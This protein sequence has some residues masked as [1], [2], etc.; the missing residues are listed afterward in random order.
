MSDDLVSGLDQSTEAPAPV[1][2]GDPQPD[3]IERVERPKE[4]RQT[5]RESVD[6]QK[7]DQAR[8]AGEQPTDRARPDDQPPDRRQ[9][10]QRDPQTGKFRP[11]EQPQP[12]ARAPAPGQPGAG[13]R[14]P[15]GWSPQAKNMF[16]GLPPAIKEAIA[17]SEFA[18]STAIDQFK[19]L[20]GVQQYADN[21]T[22]NGTTLARALENYTGI[23]TLLQ[24]DPAA[25]LMQIFRNMPGI[26][27]GIVI[28]EMLRRMGFRPNQPGQPQPQPGS[29]PQPQPYR[30]PRLDQM[31]QQMQR[32]QQMRAVEQRRQDEAMVRAA[33]NMTARFWTDP[34]YPYAENV[35]DQMVEII[36]AAKA[37]GIPPQGI[38]LVEVY[39]AACWRNPQVREI[40]Q[41]E[42]F[43]RRA[44]GGTPSRQQA[45]T[46]RA[47]A[48]SKAV[49]GSPRVGVTPGE[50]ASNP[51]RSTR[52]TI[53]DAIQA[54]KGG[55]RI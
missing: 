31:W 24:R 55:Q 54:Q 13:I 43:R 47:R 9:A 3:R 23:E 4:L 49:T 48:A 27:P 40:L 17:Q 10:A 45:A 28:Q 16:G 29:P 5:I 19:T 36:E 2:R 51:N 44:A 20:N 42:D 1:E 22:R 18:H 41:A 7:E 33:S 6:R 50:R 32:D 25:G 26:N 14:P 30:D 12:G 21:A 11:G 37:R 38:N 15:N 53:L 52:E 34:K 46:A 8:E 39:E 35:A